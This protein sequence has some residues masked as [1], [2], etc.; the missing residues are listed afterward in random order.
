MD[1]DSLGADRPGARAL[2]IL[3]DADYMYH[4][5]VY[6]QRLQGL[7]D[8]FVD[9]AYLGEYESTGGHRYFRFFAATVRGTADPAW[10]PNVSC[11]T[12]PHAYI[13][14]PRRGRSVSGIFDIYGWAMEEPSG[15]ANVEVILDDVSLITQYGIAWYRAYNLNPRIRDPQR[16]YVMFKARF[17]PVEHAPGRHTLSIRVHPVNGSPYIFGTRT[18][19]SFPP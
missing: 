18:F 7:C 8:Q 2:L 1:A 5:P 19:Y 14:Q 9:F 15:V 3:Q 12:L 13:A 6:V 10:D 4:T 11:P 17:D 16:P